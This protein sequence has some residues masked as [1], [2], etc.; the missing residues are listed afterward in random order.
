MGCSTSSCNTI[1]ENNSPFNMKRNTN[2]LKFTPTSRYAKRQVQ[3]LT[4]SRAKELFK[5]HK[6]DNIEYSQ[7]IFA[8]I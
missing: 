4:P 7:F 2:N 3:P 8:L 5:N 6:L 1:T